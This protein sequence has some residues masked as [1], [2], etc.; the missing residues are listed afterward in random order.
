MKKEAGQMVTADNVLLIN[1]NKDI[2]IAGVAKY[3]P[4]GDRK[5]FYNVWD[6]LGSRDTIKDVPALSKVAKI[7]DDVAVQ[8]YNEQITGRTAAEIE[9]AEV[10]KAVDNLFDSLG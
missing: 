5:P 8:K 3:V 1:N 7:L 2:T 10:S 6:A 4:I 9:K